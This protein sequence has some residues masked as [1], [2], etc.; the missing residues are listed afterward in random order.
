MVFIAPEL[1]KW[2]TCGGLGVMVGELTVG[3]AALGVKVTVISPFYDKNKKGTTDYLK[4]DG[5]HY[6]R[7]IKTMVGEDVVDIGLHE[8]YVNG[9]RLVFLHN[10]MYFPSPYPNTT[11]CETLRAMMLMA[12]GSLEA[13]CQLQLIPSMIVT[14]DWFTGLVAAVA[15]VCIYVTLLY[16]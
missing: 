15:K 3:L 10:A 11:S 12:K 2:T 16:Y 7:N 1:G 4:A 8:G 9:V 14:N 13:L 6:K 5:I